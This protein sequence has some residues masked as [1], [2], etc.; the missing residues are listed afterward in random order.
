MHAEPL[1]LHGAQVG[2]LCPRAKLK[3]SDN[4]TSPSFRPFLITNVSDGGLDVCI[5]LEVLLEHALLN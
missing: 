3:S 2:N 1:G 5:L 4:K